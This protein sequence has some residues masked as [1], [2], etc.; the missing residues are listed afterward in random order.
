MVDTR[1]CRKQTRSALVAIWAAGVAALSMILPPV[2]AQEV[3][4]A[5][6][7]KVQSLVTAMGDP[8]FA[9]REKATI[10]LKNLPLE[11]YAAV[12]SF[13]A[14]Q[15]DLDP[16]TRSRLQAFQRD[17]RSLA[18]MARRRQAMMEWNVQAA[19]QAYDRFGSHDPRWNA[20]A[21]QAI[22]LTIRAQWGGAGFAEAT[23]TLDAA[24]N[25]GCNDPLFL[26]YYAATKTK[27]TDAELRSWIALLREAAGGMEPSDYPP[28]RKCLVLARC[29][30][31]LAEF[32]GDGP[33]DRRD[34]MKYV[35]MA[36]K[37]FRQIRKDNELPPDFLNGLAE[38]LCKAMTS[39][40]FGW[41]ERQ[42]ITSCLERAAP[43]TAYPLILEAQY[44]LDTARQIIFLAGPDRQLVERPDP[45]Q[46]A[47]DC[48]E[49]AWQKDP[50][51]PR[52]AIEAMRDELIDRW[53]P[54]EMEKWYHRAI[55]ADPDSLHCA[56][57]KLKYLQR[58]GM[59]RQASEFAQVCRRTDNWRGGLPFIL[60]DMHW[61][62]AAQT[63][64]VAAYL[65]QPGVWE[66]IRLTYE[67]HL[68]LY[69]D[70][71]L[72]RS[73]C[74]Y[75]AVQGRQWAEADKQLRIL[76]ERPSMQVFGSMASYNYLRRKAA[77]LAGAATQ[78]AETEGR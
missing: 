41:R 64:N 21:R 56:L 38:L 26:H 57:Q 69:P 2:H 47:A 61:M 76:G 24:R 54:E 5:M 39:L 6:L 55:K 12:E 32:S 37:C 66:D 31:G 18:V 45:L 7:A 68:E 59:E 30:L 63:D 46:T 27:A 4:S 42:E 36:A 65:Q 50:D 48:L 77:R 19:G 29:G 72:R 71:V 40:E 15:A 1:Y 3:G 20:L 75:M 49:R 67:R 13:L 53:S 11:A 43:G 58:H 44:C 14:K 33:A 51:N 78:P 10:F 23:K 28:E 73:W 62:R 22:V 60:V 74:A 8:D 52:P 34:A 25:A 9:V 16:E 17:L 35:R 70:D